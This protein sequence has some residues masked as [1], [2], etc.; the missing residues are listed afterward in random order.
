MGPA[1][2]GLIEA[3]HCAPYQYVLTVT[4]GGAAAA[5]LRLGV[6]GGSRTILEVLV[7]YHGRALEAFLGREPEQSCSAETSRALA[8]RA[9]E[10]AGEL[11]PGSLVAGCGCTASLVSDRPKRG[12]HRFY[13]SVATTHGSTTWSLTLNKGGRDREGEEAVLDAVLLNALAETFGVPRRVAAGL[14]PG[15]AAHVETFPASEALARLFRG[16]SASVCVASDGHLAT[17]APRPTLLLPGSFNPLHGGHLAMAG[18]AARRARNPVAFELSIEN[19]DKAPLCVEEVCRRTRQFAWHF[20]LWL[21]RAP[22][23]LEK[24]RLFPGTTFVIGFDTVLRLLAKEYYQGSEALMK[25]VLGAIG[26]CG[27]RFLVAGRAGDD[28]A[29][30]TLEHV[31]VPAAHR[32]LFEAIPES[33]CRVDV[34]ATEIRRSATVTGTL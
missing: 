29:F 32:D 17:D 13:L 16:E 11:A 1:T 5:A 9:L 22:T 3:L 18:A 14:L 7:P 21:T 25:E 28:G 24:A 6:P 34:S 4:G 31:A 27:C 33:E 2:R 19:V 15:E 10:R 26:A 20:P 12:D 30:R 8:R 23:F